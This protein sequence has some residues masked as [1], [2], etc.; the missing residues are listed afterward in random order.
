M[1]ITDNGVGITEEQ[2]SSPKSLGLMGMNERVSFFGGK[3]AISKSEE[4]G[5]TVRVYIPIIKAK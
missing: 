1:E 2:M 4:G 5:T 3:L